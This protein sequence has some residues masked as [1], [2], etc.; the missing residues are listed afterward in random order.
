VWVKQADARLPSQHE[1]GKTMN[2]SR[3]M[4]LPALAGYTDEKTIMPYFEEFVQAFL[5]IEERGH[6]LVDNKQYNIYIRCFV[7]G[8]LA[9]EQ[10]YLGHGGGSGKT[11]RFCFLCSNT[12]HYRHKGYPG[13]CIKCRKQG[14]VYDEVTGVQKHITRVFELGER[15]L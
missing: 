13:G 5:E 6:C 1:T 10:K 2:Q 3:H 12:C 8:D 15:A 9:F 7:V 11:T 14:I 4:Y